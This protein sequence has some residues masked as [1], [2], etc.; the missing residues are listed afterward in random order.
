[1][2]FI[3]DENVPRHVF[4]RLRADGHDVTTI[5]GP[6]SGI[7]DREVLRVCPKTLG[8]IAEFSEHEPN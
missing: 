3:A 6:L 1:M 4:D 7:P 8:W 2:Q 5:A